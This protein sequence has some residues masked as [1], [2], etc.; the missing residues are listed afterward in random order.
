[1]HERTFLVTGASKGIGRALSDRLAADGH[2]IVGLARGADDPTFP[3][4]LVSVDLTDRDATARTLATLAERYAFD[5]VINNAGFVRL[6]GVEAVDLDDLE[7]S[8]R[9]NLNSAVQTVQAL[10]PGMRER[11][12]GRIVNLSSLVVLGV[13]NRTAYA[14]AKAAM[15]SFTRTWALELAE[16][17]IT[18]N[19]V[20]PGPTE[21]ELFRQNTP[22]GSEAERRFLSL[23]PMKRLGKPEELAAAVAF[24][25]SEDAG[26]ITG[27]TL[28]V[29]GGASVGKAAL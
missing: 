17:G 22:A 10:L 9:H 12:W 1:M 25:L 19:A 21:T 28:F 14:A 27:Q 11:G 16:T 26:Y 23:V 4:T 20:A 2:R 3:G 15:L 18:V 6:A 8:F 7:A 5:G 29:D 13:A 24:L